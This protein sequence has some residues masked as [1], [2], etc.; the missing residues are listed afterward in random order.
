MVLGGSGLG[1]GLGCL[2]FSY[3]TH[4]LCICL[5]LFNDLGFNVMS[6]SFIL[7][8][9]GCRPVYLPR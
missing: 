8:S 6:I 5:C 4:L 9:L 7:V 3:H 1:L 2:L